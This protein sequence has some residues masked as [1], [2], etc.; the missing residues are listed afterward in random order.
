R[1]PQCAQRPYA[2]DRGFHRGHARSTPARVPACRGGE[3]QPRARC[4]L[5]EQP[6]GPT[7]RPAPGSTAMKFEPRPANDFLAFMQTYYERCRQRIPKIVAVA[8][9]WAFEDLIPGLSDFDTRF[10]L[11]GPMSADDW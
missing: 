3:N 8:A 11:R 6:L 4:D 7:D 2:A 5:S 1:P 10:I 9:K